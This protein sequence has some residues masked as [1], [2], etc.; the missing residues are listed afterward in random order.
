MNPRAYSDV[1]TVFTV[2]KSPASRYLALPLLL[3]AVCLALLHLLVLQSVMYKRIPGG[4]GRFLGDQ[5][6]SD[7]DPTW[8]PLDTYARNMLKL[9]ESV[10]DTGDFNFLMGPSLKPFSVQ[11]VHLNILQVQRPVLAALAKN[12]ESP[13][14]IDD[15]DP[16]ASEHVLRF[17]YANE[18]PVW[19]GMSIFSL[20]NLVVTSPCSWVRPQVLCR[21]TDKTEM[22]RP[23]IIT[24]G[25]VLDLHVII[26][27]NA[28]GCALLKEN[29]LS[30]FCQETSCH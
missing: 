25:N 6:R 26:F 15:I 22:T 4:W 19:A 14:T 2:I 16:T 9:L 29:A 21:G 7:H 10:D 1:G 24:V 12:S 18:K 11:S 27:A 5:F 13:V 17:A 20:M 23:D 30:F 8:R 3:A 28:N